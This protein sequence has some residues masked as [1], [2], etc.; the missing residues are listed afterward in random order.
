MIINTGGK[1]DTLSSQQ[2]ELMPD[3]AFRELWLSFKSN[4]AMAALETMSSIV[5]GTDEGR[6]SDE[7]EFSV[8]M[9]LVGVIASMENSVFSALPE[10]PEES[11]EAE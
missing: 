3:S 7:D 5:M 4:V 9:Q 11:P 2:L 10:S 8:Y 6:S 1:M